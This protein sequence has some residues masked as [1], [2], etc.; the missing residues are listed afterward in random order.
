MFLNFVLVLHELVF[1]FAAPDVIDKY[2]LQ[3]NIKLYF[4]FN[5][6]NCTKF[7]NMHTCPRI[8]LYNYVHWRIFSLLVQLLNFNP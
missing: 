5:V 6:L 4:N 8:L 2:L 7:K 3:T 1:V